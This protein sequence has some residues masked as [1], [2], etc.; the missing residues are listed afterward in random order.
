MLLVALALLL[1]AVPF[2]LLV[3]LIE[4]K[5]AALR[6]V[7]V[8]ASDGLHSYAIHH[9]AF[10]AVMRLLSF[11]GSTTAWWLVFVPVVAWLLW[12]R[13]P[14]LAV[15]AAATVLLSSLLNNAV[16]LLVHRTRPV[17]SHPVAHAG[18]NSFP[19]GHAQAAIVG[20]AVLLLVF[21]PAL[22]GGWRRVAVAVA[23]VMVL[24][25]GFS[26]IALGVHY[27]SDVL[28]GYLLGGAW[29]AAMTAAFSAWRRER[30]RPAVR[31]RAGLEPEQAERISS[32]TPTAARRPATAPPE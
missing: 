2:L 3:L 12:R 22:H 19:S 11:L 17:L 25:I 13:L 21:L 23:M 24:A 8:G 26:R 18:G 16:K 14:R 30:G 27:L 5:S 1:V 31:A 7:D 28:A 6:G 29:V 10:V 20:F 4:D 15:Y 9:H 32:E